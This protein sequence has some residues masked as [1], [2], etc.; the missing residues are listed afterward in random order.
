VNLGHISFINNY[1][2][3]SVLRVITEV[4]VRDVLQKIPSW[5]F[6]CYATQLMGGL[7]KAEGG[8]IQKHV[9]VR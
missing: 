2:G 5:A 7:N 4:T 8:T 3:D 6:L 1:C 9:A